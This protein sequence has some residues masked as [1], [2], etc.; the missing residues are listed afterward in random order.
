MKKKFSKLKY[1]LLWYI[2]YGLLIITMAFLSDV[3]LTNIY[4]RIFLILMF[5]LGLYFNRLNNKLDKYILKHSYEIN[6][7]S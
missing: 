5:L 1:Y 2:V 4:Q 7:R 6:N 3:L